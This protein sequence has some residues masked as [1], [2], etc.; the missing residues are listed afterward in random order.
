MHNLILQIALILSFGIIVYLF[1][2]AMPRIGNGEDKKEPSLK[3]FFANIK[4]DQVDETI[5]L[6]LEK[7]LRRLKLLIMRMDNSIT[8]FLNNIKETAEKKT[9]WSPKQGLFE[10]AIKE[11]KSE[12]HKKA[13][14]HHKVV[15]KEVEKE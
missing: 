5:N 11:E 1:I 10:E 14:K 8:G 7:V 12:E 9:K 4:L 13:V 2:K 3:N 15:V 6:V